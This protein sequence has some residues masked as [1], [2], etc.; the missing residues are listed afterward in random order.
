MGLVLPK[1][2]NYLGAEALL[3]AMPNVFCHI[4]D[5]RKGEANIPLHDALMS[6]CAM[7]SLNSPSLLAF[8]KERTADNV[9]RV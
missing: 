1:P 6:A 8:D 2:R 5:H 9:Q 3:R 4:P 7:C